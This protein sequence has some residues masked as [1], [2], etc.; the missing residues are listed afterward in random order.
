MYGK[1]EKFWVKVRWK[2]DDLELSGRLIEQFRLEG[3]SGDH[4]S[5]C[6]AQNQTSIRV[7]SGLQVTQLPTR[8][9]FV[10]SFQ[11]LQRWRS[12]CFAGFQCSTTFMV[13][14]FF[15][16]TCWA[17]AAI[18]SLELLVPS[19]PRCPTCVWPPTR[20][21]L[22]TKHHPEVLFYRNIF[23]PS[24]PSLCCCLGLFCL[25]SFRALDHARAQTY[26][27]L[28]GEALASSNPS[29]KEL[30]SPWCDEGIWAR[31]MCCSAG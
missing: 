8:A 19:C 7:W 13:R 23:Y 24:A 6:P 22:V 4:W 5:K 18:P 11:C 25:I 21:P 28:W 26:G 15:P 17:E 9:I 2:W 1:W 10:L 20:A 27:E 3:T 14:L 31:P 16:N 30:A 12:H 29:R